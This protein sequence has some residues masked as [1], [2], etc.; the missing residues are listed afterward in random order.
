M[1]DEISFAFSFKATK[2]ALTETVA[3]NGL[4]FPMAASSPRTSGQVQ[5]ISTTQEIVTIPA[6]LTVPGWCYLANFDTTNFIQIGVLVSATFYPLAR[7]GP[8]ECFMIKLDPAMV[9]TGASVLYAKADT[10]ACDMQV[11]VFTA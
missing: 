2:G 4:K 11:K 10:A 6:D 9:V 8:G 7:L 5:N 3:R 1:A